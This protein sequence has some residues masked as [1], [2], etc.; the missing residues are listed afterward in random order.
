MEENHTAKII[1]EAEKSEKLSR[2][3][4][5][6]QFPLLIRK[7][8][9]FQNLLKTLSE[10]GGHFFIQRTE[11]AMALAIEAWNQ[12]ALDEKLRPRIIFKDIS[13]IKAPAAGRE[14]FFS[15]DSFSKECKTFFPQHR[16]VIEDLDGPIN[17]GRTL[18]L[19]INETKTSGEETLAII[20]KQFLEYKNKV[21]LIWPSQQQIFKVLREKLLKLEAGETYVFFCQRNGFKT[22]SLDNIIAIVINSKELKITSL[23]SERKYRN[24]ILVL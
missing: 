1:R 7:F 14:Y 15:G 3:L 19:E 2:K 8:S 12:A 17:S 13:R 5:E 6:N 16:L 11:L 21:D 23:R 4:T 24:P 20:L 9:E 18:S 22:C 10:D